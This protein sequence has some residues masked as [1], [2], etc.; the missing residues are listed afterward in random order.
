MLV[1]NRT[2]ANKIYRTIAAEEPRVRY[3][4]NLVEET[5]AKRNE[6]SCA[7]CGEEF[8]NTDTVVVAQC[9]VPEC[10]G[11]LCRIRFL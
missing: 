10:D 1:E 8:S 11:W 2:E 6:D 9:G 4:K 7:I 5:A 3:L